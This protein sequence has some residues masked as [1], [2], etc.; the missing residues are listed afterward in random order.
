MVLGAPHVLEA[1]AVGRLDDLDVA[2]DPLVLGLGVLLELEAGHEQLGEDAE[3]HGLSLVRQEPDTASTPR[4]SFP[5]CRSSSA[6]V[7]WSS[8]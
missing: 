8:G 7:T 5:W 3:L 4:L 1:G 6:C 2:E